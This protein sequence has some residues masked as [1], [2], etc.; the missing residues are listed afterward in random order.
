MIKVVLDTSVLVS[1]FLKPGGANA[2]IL[3]KGETQFQLCLSE[4]ILEETGLALLTYE[5]IRRK[6]MYA[7]NEVF[8]YLAML[9]ITAK[10]VLRNLPKIRVIIRDPKDDHVLACA[11]KVEA[12]Y[13]VSKDDH[14]KDLKEYKGIKILSSQDFL[15]ILKGS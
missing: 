5:R 10:E 11:S 6:Y 9:R 7:D 2:L 3:Q 4:E 8:E 1:A 12:A 15:K 14:L 13:I